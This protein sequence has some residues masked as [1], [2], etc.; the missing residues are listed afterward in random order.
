MNGE[1]SIERVKP[2]DKEEIFELSSQIWEG[3]DYIPE[4]FDEWVQEE[5]FYCGKL[6][7]KIISVDKY[8]W[9]YNDVIWL[10]GLRVHPD[11]RGKGYARKTVDA[12]MEKV[13]ELGYKAVRFLT[14]STKWP[15]RRM[16]GD[17][18]FKIKEEYDYLR[19]DEESLEDIDEPVVS[20]EIKK[21]TD[22]KEVKQFILNSFEYDI[23]KHQFIRH[24]TTYDIEEELLKKEIDQSR[25]FYIR[26]DKINALAFFD[27]TDIYDSLCIPF[28]SGF[29][30]DMFELMKFGLKRCLDIDYSSYTIKTA[31]SD[32][33]SAAQELG[34]TYTHSGSVLLFEKT[35]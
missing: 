18:G 28:I 15:V 6:D 29:Y 21:G 17:Y 8:T 30:E 23:N 24:W 5:G 2:S 19:L 33:I 14:S 22:L 25:C 27:Y 32:V 11:Y 10:E 13:D 35:K 3:R 7:G 26:N 4:V 31:S 16:A 1:F 12:L 34:M 9:Q 20:T